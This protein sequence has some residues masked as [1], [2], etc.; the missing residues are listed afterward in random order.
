MRLRCSVLVALCLATVGFAQ[1]GV[2]VH[3]LQFTVSKEDEGT[4]TNQLGYMR[5]AF[6]N[7]SGEDV[8]LLRTFDDEST[9]RFWFSVVVVATNGTP[10]LDTP[11]GGK[12]S[13]RGAREYLVL[14][15]QE[16][17]SFRLDSSKL[18]PKLS[19]GSYCIKVV[20]SNQYGEN[21]FHGRMESNSLDMKVP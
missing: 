2:N 14:K 21:C 4:A 6:K 20:Y 8:R 15:P 16:S 1:E 9:L 18:V 7:V 5:V 11:A 12:I 19:P 3:P 17:F 10:V 13:V